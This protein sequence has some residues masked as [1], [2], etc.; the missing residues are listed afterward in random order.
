VLTK[1]P[2][3]DKNERHGGSSPD[4]A[5]FFVSSRIFFFAQLTPRSSLQ[6]FTSRTYLYGT[7]GAVAH[8]SP[9]FSGD[10]TLSFLYM[11]KRWLD[12]PLQPTWEAVEPC[13]AVFGMLQSFRLLQSLCRQLSQT[14][15][16]LTLPTLHAYELTLQLAALQLLYLMCTVR[17]SFSPFS[18]VLHSLLCSHHLSLLFQTTFVVL[19]YQHQCSRIEVAQSQKAPC[20]L[21]QEG[22]PWGST[23]FYVNLTSPTFFPNLNLPSNTGQ[24]S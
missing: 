15:F 24:L 3:R 7:Y 10:R 8:P 11:Y 17:V 5:N 1:F 20:V 23:I 22:V 6:R 16:H 4:L 13:N 21:C 14:F 19:P 2:D 18:S 9:H 12:I